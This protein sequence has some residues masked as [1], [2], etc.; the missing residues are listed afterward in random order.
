MMCNFTFQTFNVRSFFFLS[1]CEAC[2]ELRG[3]SV[4][5][6]FKREMEVFNSSD[7]I[8]MSK[9]IELFLRLEIL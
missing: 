8:T 5:E 9:L 6:N 3:Q 1:L 7:L 2:F 4:T